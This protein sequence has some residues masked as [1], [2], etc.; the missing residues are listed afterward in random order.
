[1]ASS[2]GIIVVLETEDKVPAEF[3]FN[4]GSYDKDLRTTPY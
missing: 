4:K 2:Q 3:R 1:M